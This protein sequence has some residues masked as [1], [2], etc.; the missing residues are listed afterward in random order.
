MTIAELDDEQREAFEIDDSVE[1]GVV[2][3]RSNRIRR[4]ARK[5][6]RPAR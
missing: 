4:P 3:T 6:S 2:I 1:S 5:G